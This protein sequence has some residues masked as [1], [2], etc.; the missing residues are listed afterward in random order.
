MAAEDNLKFLLVLDEPCKQ[1]A[2]AHPSEI[3]A[4]LAPILNCVRIVW[5]LSRFYNTPERITVSTRARVEG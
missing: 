2:Q 4:L 3:P 5:G 1:L